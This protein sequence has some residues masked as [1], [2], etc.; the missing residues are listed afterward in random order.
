[1]RNRFLILTVTL[2]ALAALPLLVWLPARF[3][4]EQTE[5]LIRRGRLA[6]ELLDKSAIGALTVY[7]R[8]ALDQ[9][10]KGFIR[11]SDF[12]YVLILDKDRQL[13]ADSGVEK[14][15]VIQAEQLF[16]ELLR[17]DNDAEIRAKWPRTNETAIHI[18]RPV[19]YE[20][21]RIG[22]IVLGISGRRVALQAG[23]LRMQ[24]ILACGG[25]LALGLALSFFLHRSLSQPLRRIAQG[26]DVLPDA[27]LESLAGKVKEYNLL[28]EGLAKQRN[29]FRSSLS[30]L[31]T[32][33]LQL[34]A[35]LGQSR[36]EASS[37]TSKLGAMG[38]QIEALQEKIRAIEE[39]SHH[40][41][42]VLPVVQFA[43]GIAPEIDASMQQISQSAGRLSEDLGRLRNLINLYEKALPQSQEDLEVIRQ[44]KAFIS[45]EQIQESMDELVT[46]IRGG[47]SWAEQLADILKQ[48]STAPMPQA[49]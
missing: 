43:T 37:L 6:A 29:L 39:Q 15:D 25:V 27:Q 49:K 14:E 19:F 36:E 18:S 45:Y 26:L 4:E 13:L 10:A 41:T 34:E 30:E 21:L 20:Q 38:K 12:L 11:S 3:E 9:I 23:L 2:T 16:P 42:K 35:E 5:E 28:V 44:Y 32:Q 47:A 22:T 48:L 1:M 40:L 24:M 8:G 17:S 31:E 33:K 46:T 7:D